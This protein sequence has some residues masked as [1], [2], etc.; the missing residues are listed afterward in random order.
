MNQILAFLQQHPEAQAAVAGALVSV[1]IS[2]YKRLRPKAS[3]EETAKVRQALSA[4]VLSLVAGAITTG[5][6]GGGWWPQLLL[7]AAAAW[8]ASQAAYGAG[9]SAQKVGG[10]V[11]DTA[12]ALAVKMTGG[13][14]E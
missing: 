13:I 10:A 2:I 5:A 1:A 6:A 8:L 11:A 12:A 14:D 4:L 7:N 9:K 3:D